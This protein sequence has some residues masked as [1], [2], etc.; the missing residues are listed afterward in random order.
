MHAWEHLC[1]PVVDPPAR[2]GTNIERLV[3]KAKRV[4]PPARGGTTGSLFVLVVLGVDPPA[5][6]RHV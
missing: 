6:G 5:Q 3:L 2:G 4:Y 1:H